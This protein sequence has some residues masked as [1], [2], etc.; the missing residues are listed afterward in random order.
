M[1]R[2]LKVVLDLLVLWIL[3]VFFMESL[4]FWQRGLNILAA[5][6][7]VRMAWFYS[8]LPIG[9]AVLILVGVELLIKDVKHALDRSE[10]CP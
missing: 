6:M 9:F 8:I 4:G 5:T 2:I 10:P 1:G 7:P 3:Y